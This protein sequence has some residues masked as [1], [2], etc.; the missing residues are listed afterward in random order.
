MRQL[1]RDFESALHRKC[2]CERVKG[3]L[4][5]SAAATGSGS[6]LER[7]KAA[8]SYY[9]LFDYCVFFPYSCSHSVLIISFFFARRL[10]PLAGAGRGGANA[11]GTGRTVRSL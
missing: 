5:P 6:P 7:R 8:G 11:D 3:A 2:I 4:A 1:A 10:D 9:D